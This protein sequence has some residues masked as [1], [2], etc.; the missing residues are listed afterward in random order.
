ML[1][2]DGEAK[3]HGC[4]SLSSSHLVGKIDIRQRLIDLKKKE[5]FIINSEKAIDGKEL[6]SLSTYCKEV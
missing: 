2:F 3:S 4:C 5:F 1:G 6:T